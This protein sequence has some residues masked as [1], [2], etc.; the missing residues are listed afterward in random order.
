MV[1]RRQRKCIVIFERWKRKRN[2]KKYLFIYLFLGFTTFM[3]N[4]LF[5]SRRFHIKNLKQRLHKKHVEHIFQKCALLHSRTSARLLLAYVLNLNVKSNIAMQ[6]QQRIYSV[7]CTCNFYSNIHGQKTPFANGWFMQI[8]GLQKAK[9]LRNGT[10]TEL[11]WI[12]HE[13]WY[14]VNNREPL[15]IC[16]WANFLPHIC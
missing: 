7:V 16:I 10:E 6:N 4:S 9:T 3:F 8:F 14:K 12:E 2:T 1:D 5:H 13:T 15:Q 11:I